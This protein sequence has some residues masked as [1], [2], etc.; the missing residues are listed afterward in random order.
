[1]VATAVASIDTKL[2]AAFVKSA[3]NVLQVMVGL[4]CQVGK[5]YLK[6]ESS[7]NYDVSGIV[8]FSGDVVGSVVVSFLED[9]AVKMVEKFSGMSLTT[10]SEDFVDAVGELCNMIA[11]NAK[12]DFGLN[13]SISIP[14][15][16]IGTAHT[17][18]RMKDVPCIAIPCHSEC[19]DFSVEV[20]IKQLK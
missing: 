19:G 16:V 17:I 20:N 14:N 7:P 8:G 3:T 5:P 11:G 1:M 13:A 10:K 18:A 2:I 4:H 6:N 9:T 15:V 12:K